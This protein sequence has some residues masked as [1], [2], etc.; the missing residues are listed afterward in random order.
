[1]ERK[2]NVLPPGT[3]QPM[4]NNQTAQNSNY[5]LISTANSSQ[6]SQ[7]SGMNYK[8]LYNFLPFD[9]NNRASMYANTS[10]ASPH[11]TI[12]NS[13]L[14]QTPIE[15]VEEPDPIDP[16]QQTI[17]AVGN[18]MLEVQA[19]NENLNNASNTLNER[20]VEKALDDIQNKEKADEDEKV[21]EEEKENE[22]EKVDEEKVDEEKE[23]KKTSRKNSPASMIENN[24]KSNS[25][26]PITKTIESIK[27]ESFNSQTTASQL[28][29]QITEYDLMGKSQPSIPDDSSSQR[30]LASG[31]GDLRRQSSTPGIGS[32]SSHPNIQ[33]LGDARR[34]FQPS[35]SNFPQRNDSV[36]NDQVSRSSTVRTRSSSNS[37][38][39]SIGIQL[40]ARGRVKQDDMAEA[41][42]DR[43]PPQNMH[44]QQQ[45]QQMHPSGSPYN[46]VP[47]NTIPYGRGI[48]T[49]HIP[50]QNQ[51]AMN[52]SQDPRVSSPG[53]STSV[54]RNNSRLR[55]Q[56][57][58][59]IYQNQGF[60]YDPRQ[61]P[62][63][64]YNNDPRQPPPQAY[65]NDPR[66]PPP[67]A[68]NN[69]PRQPPPQ[70]Y[71]NMFTT[72][73]PNGAGVQRMDDG[74]QVLF[75]VKALYDYKTTQAEEIP[76]L[77]NDVIAV[78]GTNPD[79]WWEGELLDDSRKKRGLFPSNYIQILE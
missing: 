59:Q 64:A 14:P 56:F 1:M 63:Q 2:N 13:A 18:N 29:N 40:D 54:G 75:L 70:S 69:D 15:E 58:Q 5:N 35:N 33:G 62:P 73:R 44:Y 39:T 6:S 52:S 79:G 74:R 28:E 32:G 38:S 77:A 20:S 37:N 42:F 11:G 53:S 25:S 17:L 12:R 66:Q 3:D 31:P 49:T 24:F 43:S 67:Q 68:Y 47:S 41:F 22:E 51:L 60:Y 21:D 46:T 76:F 30:P 10:S 71:N 36:M 16:R 48:P 34:S 50:T 78:L 8:S 27:D 9:K 61:Q 26:S 65:N 4:G 23:E 45:Q 7:E 57:P 55:G 72:Q 19:T